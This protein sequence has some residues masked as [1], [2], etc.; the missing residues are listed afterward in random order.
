MDTRRTC[1]DLGNEMSRIL[2]WSDRLILMICAIGFMMFA[3]T[4][5]AKMN[6]THDDTRTLAESLTLGTS[7]EEVVSALDAE[8]A[9]YIITAGYSIVSIDIVRAKGFEDLGP[10]KVAVRS[11][12]RKRDTWIETILYMLR[13][14][15][16]NEAL[17]LSFDEQGNLFEK[18]CDKTVTSF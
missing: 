4:A 3:E 2:Y 6:C 13:L 7:F 10:V 14:Y 15:W 16:T 1:Y 11:K 5:E 9:E 12:Q 18:S 17:G 8:N